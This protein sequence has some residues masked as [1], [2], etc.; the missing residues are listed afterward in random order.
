MVNNDLLLMIFMFLCVIR[1]KETDY[2]SN[3]VEERF[4]L[5]S[6]FIQ[7][8]LFLFTCMVVFNL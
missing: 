7:R 6:E 5:I 2:T 3:S 8:K 4:A 1:K